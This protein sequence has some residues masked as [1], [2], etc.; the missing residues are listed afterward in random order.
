MRVAKAFKRCDNAKSMQQDLAGHWAEPGTAK[1]N[2]VL[3][4]TVQPGTVLKSPIMSY[5]L[6]K[7]ALRGY[8]I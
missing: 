4:G 8:Q 6:E 7:Q 5:I 3:P 1:Y 2:R